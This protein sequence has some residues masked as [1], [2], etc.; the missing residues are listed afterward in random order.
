EWTLTVE[1]QRRIRALEMKCYITILGMIDT[2]GGTDCDQ[3]FSSGPQAVT[4]YGTF[5]SPNRPN[6]YPENKRCMYKFIGQRNEKVKLRFTAF[7]IQGMPP[8]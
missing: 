1:L 3:T 4:K 6:D 5:A 7:R 2:S 8:T